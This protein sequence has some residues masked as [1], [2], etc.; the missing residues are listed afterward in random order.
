MSENQACSL[1]E[2]PSVDSFTT[3]EKKAVL[4][5]TLDYNHTNFDHGCYE[6]GMDIEVFTGKL[7]ERPRFF[8]TPP[9]LRCNEEDKPDDKGTRLSASVSNI[10][11]N[12]VGSSQVSVCNGDAVT[13]LGSPLAVPCAVNGVSSST[14]PVLEIPTCSNP[15]IVER[16]DF[17]GDTELPFFTPSSSIDK[18]PL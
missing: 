13:P 18:S 9:V 4:A 7:E 12:S 11:S 6:E 14:V 1:E 16:T 2:S 5:A 8:S 15:T 17:E 3:S 10:S